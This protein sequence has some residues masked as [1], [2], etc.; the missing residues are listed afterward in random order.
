[1]ACSKVRHLLQPVQRCIF[2]ISVRSKA[3]CQYWKH[4]NTCSLSRLAEA[5]GPTIAGNL[6]VFQAT[7]LDLVFD[8]KRS[9]LPRDT[10]LTY[11]LVRDM[12]TNDVLTSRKRKCLTIIRTYCAMS[13]DTLLVIVRHFLLKLC[14]VLYLLLVGRGPLSRMKP[15][16]PS[17]SRPRWDVIEMRW[18]S[19]QLVT[20]TLFFL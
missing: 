19:L 10:R 5:L 9:V 11:T 8:K 13:T 14:F 12:V 3:I 6:S 15:C 1:M 7:I 17:T 18:S 16:G 4:C 2:H 20:Q